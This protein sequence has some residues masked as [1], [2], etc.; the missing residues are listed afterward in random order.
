VHWWAPLLLVL[1]YTPASFVMFPRPLITMAAVVTVGPWE[2]LGYAMTGVLLAAVVGYALGRNINRNRVRRIAGARLN[3]IAAV[4]HHRGIVAVALVRF[5]PIAPYLVVNVVMG[6][7]RVKF[8]HYIIGTFLGM[9]PGGL[10]ATVL[11]DQVARA[12]R[13]PAHINGW[14]IA[15]AVCGFAAL[16][17]FGH[18]MLDRLSHDPHDRMPPPSFA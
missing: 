17:W 1:A 9:L 7:M 12:L 14:L 6:A 4:M 3:R 11:S 10:A 16:A 18:R 13:D 15:A 2:G 8:S 5:V